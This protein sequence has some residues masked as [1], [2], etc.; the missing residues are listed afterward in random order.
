LP[1]ANVTWRQI[2]GAAWLCGIGFTMSLF[3]AG[4]AFDDDSLLSIAKMAILGASL[5]SGICGY[6]TLAKSAPPRMEQAESTS[7]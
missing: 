6:L 5:L 1:P 7:P 2:F 3:V 4:L